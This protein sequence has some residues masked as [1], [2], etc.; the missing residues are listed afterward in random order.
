M[1]E[2]HLILSNPHIVARLNTASN[3]VRYQKA[4]EK[5]LFEKSI[6]IH[7][8]FS[9]DIKNIEPAN[10][11]LALCYNSNHRSF[12]IAENGR[13][14]R[15]LYTYFK[16]HHTELQV[17]KDPDGKR[18]INKVSFVYKGQEVCSKTIVSS[19]VIGILND[20]DNNVDSD[21]FER[22][23]RRSFRRGRSGEGEK[24]DPSFESLVPF[25]VSFY[26][27]QT[28]AESKDKKCCIRAEDSYD[29]YGSRSS[30]SLDAVWQ[31]FYLSHILCIGGFDVKKLRSK[32]NNSYHSNMNYGRRRYSIED[33]VPVED[34]PAQA[35]AQPKAEEQ[36]Q[37]EAQPQTEDQPHAEAQPKA[38]E[39]PQ[40][41]GRPQAEGQA[42]QKEKKPKK[43]TEADEPKKKKYTKRAPLKDPMIYV[44]LL[45][46]IRK[47]FNS[48]H[49]LTSLQKLLLREQVERPN[50]T[51]S[52]IAE[53]LP[54]I[55]EKVLI[56]RYFID[57]LRLFTDLKFKLDSY[58][59]KAKKANKPSALR[60]VAS[61]DKFNKVLA[62]FEEL[63]KNCEG[64][65]PQSPEDVNTG[66]YCFS[67]SDI[68]TLC[69]KLLSIEMA[70][71]D[72]TRILKVYKDLMVSNRHCQEDK[73]VRETICTTL[74]PENP[75]VK[76]FNTG[77]EHRKRNKA[78]SEE[79]NEVKFDLMSELLEYFNHCEHELDSI[80]K[81]ENFK[82]YFPIRNNLSTSMDIKPRIDS[83]QF[84][85]FQVDWNKSSIKVIDKFT[86]NTQIVSVDTQ[87]PLNERPNRPDDLR[88][89]RV[90]DLLKIVCYCGLIQTRPQPTFYFICQK[91]DYNSRGRSRS[92]S[93]VEEEEI[94]NVN[95]EVMEDR[96]GPPRRRRDD[97]RPK[98]DPKAE[99]PVDE[100][101]TI[102][103][104]WCD[105]YGNWNI[106]HTFIFEKKPCHPSDIVV[107]THQDKRTGNIK[108]IV[109][110]KDY[111][112]FVPIDLNGG[113]VAPNVQGK[114]RVDEMCTPGRV[115]EHYEYL[116][117]RGSEFFT[118]R[119]WRGSKDGNRYGRGRGRGE[120]YFYQRYNEERDE[121]IKMEEQDKEKVCMLSFED[122]Q[123]LATNNRQILFPVLLFKPF[124]PN[125]LRV[126]CLAV[127]LTKVAPLVSLEIE[128]A[129]GASLQD[130]SITP[131]SVKSGLY[132]F[133]F[134]P[135]EATYSLLAL[136][137]GD[138][139]EMRGFGRDNSFTKHI[140]SLIPKA[141]SRSRGVWQWDSY[142]EKLHFS[143]TI[144]KR[145]KVE[146]PYL[147]LQQHTLIDITFR[148]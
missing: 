59:I 18:Y 15:E 16:N 2:T 103:R 107:G 67:D 105:D 126:L 145:S 113:R 115:P 68:D 130:V 128:I 85:E 13:F 99:K 64:K 94:A 73:K 147:N 137:R 78:F 75:W 33:E 19:H 131:I 129:G 102:A 74:F 47:V 110:D 140:K 111:F 46:V 51:V 31:Y 32:H 89:R 10:P 8:Q 106:E 70:K 43:P 80:L 29:R 69:S 55:Y 136:N 54:I 41:E 1:N 63:F 120:H 125:P 83:I 101:F 79:N 24:V 37:A 98:R 57:V 132:L 6:P 26:D 121:E 123:K 7:N 53:L 124:R 61:L 143:A 5:K 90:Q 84:K 81:D 62:T 52:S 96:G 17:T 45:L 12:E 34:V 142:S 95:E 42:N 60:V 144:L 21:Y 28:I 122:A 30:T 92:I 49:I 127:W 91:T 44:N 87:K 118:C 23:P 134:N 117:K 133:V 86:T 141:T 109:K 100:N 20:D 97:R 146:G 27:E 9:I 40:A 139:I 119:P 22:R 76:E 88:P 39:Q 72:K 77:L 108:L 36:P 50:A 135:V 138:I 71:I 148:I 66:K 35:E 65:T 114:K 58:C 48:Y 38:E 82:L 3:K 93:P 11:G 4:V 14:D 25:K 112:F 104:L 56:M 116:T